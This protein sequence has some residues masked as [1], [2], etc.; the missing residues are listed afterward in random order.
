MAKEFTYKMNI[1]AD[2][3][4]L[5]N[6]LKTLK[7]TLSS[8]TSDGKEP[9]LAKVLEQLGTHLDNIK[10]KANT[11]IKSEAAFGSMEKEIQTVYRLLESLSEEMTAVSKKSASE[12]I[13][14]LPENEQKK[15]IAFVNA[16]KAYDNAIETSI[17]KT[18]ELT[19]AEEQVIKD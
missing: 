16:M 14:F 7:E 19:K 17:K 11:P 5:T 10:S 4:A 18:K 12:K 1:D 9:R 6:K 2:I 13:S 15:L 8:I 3:G